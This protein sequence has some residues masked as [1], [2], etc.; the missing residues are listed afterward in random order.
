MTKLSYTIATEQNVPFISEVYAQNAAA[1]HGN[2]RT[3]EM[4]RMLLLDKDVTYYIVYDQTPVAWFRTETSADTLWLGM[5]Q[6]KPEH[7]RK[8]V[9]K[10]ILSVAE[11]L[12][13]EQN[14]QKVGIH[15]TEDNVAARTLYTSAGYTV[16]EIGPCTT[17][18][19]VERIGYTF[20]KELEGCEE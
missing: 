4:W 17:A 18:D 6:V 8:G 13:R 19:G 1:L 3:H 15:T 16:T 9:G 5:L 2:T 7:Q 20:Q 11:G 14:F 10:Y 12:A